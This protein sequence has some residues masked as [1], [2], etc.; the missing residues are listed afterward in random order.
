M[1][2]PTMDRWQQNCIKRKHPGYTL[3]GSKRAAFLESI[4]PHPKQV[5]SIVPGMAEVMKE[6]YVPSCWGYSPTEGTHTWGNITAQWADNS[7]P[8]ITPNNCDIDATG[9]IVST[10]VSNV[11]YV[12]RKWDGLTANSGTATSNILWPNENPIYTYIQSNYPYTVDPKKMKEEQFRQKMKQQ[13][14]GSV[15]LNH[16]GAQPR[17]AHRLA[18]FSQVSPSEIVALRL[19]RSM[20]DGEEWKRYLRYGFIIVRGESGLVYQIVRGQSHVRVFR[21]GKKVAELCIY[22][23]GNVPST[24]SVIAKKVMVECSEKDLWHKANIHGQS[25]WPMKY[26]PTEEELVQLAA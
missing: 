18:D 24:D 1:L 5:K 7:G 12:T 4:N 17:F 26:Q 20:L 23:Q 13:I 10:I 21:G 14:T 25:K 19:L 6:I 16:R 15:P 22:V 9:T 3:P 11:I 8:Y 2:A